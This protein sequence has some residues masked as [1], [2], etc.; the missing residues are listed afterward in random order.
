LP[1]LLTAGGESN[2]TLEGGTHNPF[3]PPFDF[4]QKTYLPVVARMGPTVTA[5]LERHGFYPAGGGCLK[6]NVQPVESL[7]PLE[8]ID[9]GEISTRRVRAVVANLPRHIAERE[10]STIAR[11]TGWERSCF[12]VE[13][14]NDSP[15]PGNAVMIEMASPAVTEVF[16]GFG[17][18][19]VKA[20]QVATQVLGEAR[21]WA[22]AD[23][24]VGQYL[25]DQLM[26]PLGIGAWQ[27]TG[28]GAFRT[29][30]LSMHS[31]THLEILRT[32]LDIRIE[33]LGQGRTDWLVRISPP[34]S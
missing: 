17:K 27:G 16:T 33:A 3:A 34:E 25:A 12:D 5:T 11:K 20:E 31:K 30:A 6:V 26:L 8:L 24:P 10:C 28:G 2:L 1:A 15:G 7:G 21:R 22:K 14:A 4:L 19:G 29:L 13:E 23:V 18:I 32:F 9:R